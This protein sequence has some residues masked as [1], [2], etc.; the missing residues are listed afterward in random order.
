MDVSTI[1][2]G[3]IPSAGLFLLFIDLNIGRYRELSSKDV[4][5]YSS[6]PR[7]DAGL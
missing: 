1:G 5:S 3:Q 7:L 4:R 2:D 6:R